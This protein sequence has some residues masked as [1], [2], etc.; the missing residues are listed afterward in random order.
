[1][2]AVVRRAAKATVVL[3]LGAAVVSG[4]G[5]S[6]SHNGP[7]TVTPGGAGSSAPASSTPASSAPSTHSTP[8]GGGYGY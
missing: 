5:K 3:A 7:S 8:S 6:S 4:C 1:M 2:S